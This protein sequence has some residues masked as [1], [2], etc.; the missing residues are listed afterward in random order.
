MVKIREVPN[1]YEP[2]YIPGSAFT[3]DEQNDFTRWRFEVDEMF[4]IFEQELLGRT[5][6]YDRD[7]MEVFQEAKGVVPTMTFEGAREVIAMCEIAVNKVTMLSGLE[8]NEVRLITR[9]FNLALVDVLFD[10]WKKWKVDKGRLDMI[11]VKST[12][13]VFVALKHSQD[14]LTLN[15]LTK[16]EQVR[17]N[18][19]EG[20][21]KK[22]TLKLNP[23][24]G[25]N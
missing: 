25:G 19:S 16:V 14:A 10:N 3:D 17:R 13:L 9:E 8:K 1:D 5:K 15:S 24:G 2:Q 11:V 12:R 23:L 4:R 7:G 6:V 18:I 20:G 22:D 21:P